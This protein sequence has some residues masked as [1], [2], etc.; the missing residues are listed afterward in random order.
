MPRALTQEE[1]ETFNAIREASN[2]ALIQVKY[3]GQETSAIVFVND[4]NDGYWVSPAAILVTDDMFADIED[5][6]PNDSNS[7]RTDSNSH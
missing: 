5:P 2:V 1:T 3:R 7:N 6:T 4:T